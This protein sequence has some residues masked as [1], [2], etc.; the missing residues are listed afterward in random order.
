[1]TTSPGAGHGHE[2]ATENL[3]LV[4]PAVVAARERARRRFIDAL[5]DVLTADGR[6]VAAWLGGSIARG[7]DDALSDVDLCIVVSDE[8]AATL[9]A[10]PRQLAGYTTAERA[11]LFD[12]FG[13]PALIHENQHNAPEGD[14]FT[15]VVYASL[16]T[17]DWVF[18]PRA[19]AVRPSDAH[20][21]FDKEGI[22]VR[23]PSPLPSRA[24]RA[25]RASERVAFFW[26]MIS[27]VVKRLLRGDAVGVNHM[28]A[29][30][31][32]LVREVW[33]LATGLPVPYTTKSSFPIAATIEQ[34][35]AAVR[36]FYDTML[37]LSPAIEALGGYV[38]DAPMAV[39]DSLLVALT[40]RRSRECWDVG[41]LDER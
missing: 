25:E 33:T 12:R 36:Q 10:R 5:V 13:R 39:V 38:P 28:L 19:L 4:D 14:S 31:E 22:P 24:Q 21:L 6:Y 30:L 1:M 17:V 37:A 35:V 41:E 27:I 20:L 40:V 15:C 34:Q 9:C 16:L 26:L 8:A 3:P 7:D 23:P 2:V 11:A 18:V 32:P 29:G